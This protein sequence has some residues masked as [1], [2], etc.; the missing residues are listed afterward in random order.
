MLVRCNKYKAKF[1]RGSSCEHYYPH[2]LHINEIL[3]YSK[4]DCSA[5]VCLGLDDKYHPVKC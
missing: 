1:C 4:I 5:D 3:N 2:E